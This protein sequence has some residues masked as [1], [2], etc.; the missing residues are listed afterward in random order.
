MAREQGIISGNTVDR[1]QLKR[2]QP[3][4][5]GRGEDRE[6]LPAI[7]KSNIVIESGTTRY[8]L[9]PDAKERRM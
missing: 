8:G 5:R 9:P 4:R 2:I 7:S 1:W 6:K 3:P